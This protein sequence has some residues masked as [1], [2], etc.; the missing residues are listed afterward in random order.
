VQVGAQISAGSG[1]WAVACNCL[2]SRAAPLGR[3]SGGT[4]RLLVCTPRSRERFEERSGGAIIAGPGQDRD[5]GV[6]HTRPART[7]R[8]QAQ[9][10]GHGPVG[11][12][13]PRADARS[14]ASAD[15]SA[16]AHGKI[17]ATAS[18]AS[19]ANRHGLRPCRSWAGGKPGTIKRFDGSLRAT[20]SGHPLDASVGDGAPGQAHGNN[21][22][23]NGGLWHEVPVQWSAA[24]QLQDR[25]VGRRCPSRGPA[26][27]DEEVSGRQVCLGFLVDS[28][29][30]VRGRIRRPAGRETHRTGA[31]ST[32]GGRAPCR[33]ARDP[34]PGVITM[35]GS[36]MRERPRRPGE[37]W[38]DGAPA[39]GAATQAVG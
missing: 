1:L 3:G 22:S 19:P 32:A 14:L 23:L 8:R 16:P 13:Q 6:R 9:L 20:G 26:R 10:R 25:T 29:A 24:P 21:L 11:R 36:A 12:L 2:S 35:T 4:A 31:P 27:R 5:P 28:S 39:P 37:Q 7:Y 30:A 15:S 33:S 38:P 17:A 34:Y 18:R